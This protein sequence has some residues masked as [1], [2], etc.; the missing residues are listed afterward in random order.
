M[1]PDDRERWT[2]LWRGYLDFYQVTLPSAIYGATWQRLLDGGPVN[3]L[4]LRERAGG[5]LIG[6]VHDLFHP[7]ADFSHY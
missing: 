2:S 5:P 7:S 4:G 1:L 3:G 6:N